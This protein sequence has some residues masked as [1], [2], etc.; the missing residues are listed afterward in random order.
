MTCPNER[1]NRGGVQ[2]PELSRSGWTRTLGRD[3]ALSASLRAAVGGKTPAI[4]EKSAN[5]E[6]HM[7]TQAVLTMPEGVAHFF[8]PKP[9]TPLW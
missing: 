3:T 8:P 7:A 2:A 9:A 6:G 4:M 1:G 5:F